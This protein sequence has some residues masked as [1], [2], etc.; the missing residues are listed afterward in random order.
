M[1]YIYCVGDWSR[2]IALR[3][4]VYYIY[5]DI[6]CVGD[7]SR[8]IALRDGDGVYY[9]YIYIDIVLGIGAGL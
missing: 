4:G 1:Y 3:D 9:I 5:I 8:T 7:W 2:T 6:Y